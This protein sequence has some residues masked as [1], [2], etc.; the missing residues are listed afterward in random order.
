MQ[1]Y[2]NQQLDTLHNTIWPNVWLTPNST[3]ITQQ[4]SCPFSLNVFD[5]KSAQ[6]LPPWCP[7]PSLSSSLSYV[8]YMGTGWDFWN[9][10]LDK[11]VCRSDPPTL[12][13]LSFTKVSTF[14]LMIRKTVQKSRVSS[15]MIMITISKL[16]FKLCYLSL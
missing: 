12:T 4:K 6:I 5:A 9:V 10:P 1:Y 8:S 14:F 2:H 7:P 13:L 16:Y 11:N 3:S 15:K